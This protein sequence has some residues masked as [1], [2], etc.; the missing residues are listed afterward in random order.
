VRLLSTLGYLVGAKIE[1]ARMET[2]NSQLSKR[3]ETLKAVD[4]AKSI[5]Q[6]DLSLSEDDA[7]QMMHRESRHAAGYR[8]CYPSGRRAATSTDELLDICGKICL[9]DACLCVGG[10][11]R[12]FRLPDI[13]ATLQKRGRRT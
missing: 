11:E 4:R 10:G 2:E 8:R 12:R 5:L 3:L 7:Y 13:S 9:C 1:L 6:H